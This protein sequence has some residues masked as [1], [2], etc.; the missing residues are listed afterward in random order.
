MTGTS[1]TSAKV[2][3]IKP[4]D[5]DGPSGGGSANLAVNEFPPPAPAM[6]RA[7]ARS[8][9]RRKIGRKALRHEGCGFDF[10]LTIGVRLQALGQGL[11]RQEM[12]R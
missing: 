11:R 5:R 1:A 8:R 12:L 4:L 6:R 10:R 3:M 9:L 2:N 7:P